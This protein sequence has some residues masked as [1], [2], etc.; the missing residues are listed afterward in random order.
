MKLVVLVFFICSSVI[1]ADP[2]Q[3]WYQ[4]QLNT[5]VLPPY[6]D[7]YQ[8]L[9][10]RVVNELLSVN[11]TAL[12]EVS[13]T[14]LANRLLCAARDVRASL[15]RSVAGSNELRNQ[16]DTK[17]TSSVNQIGAYEQ[18][19]VEK[20]VEIEQTNQ[21]LRG[22]EAALDSAKRAVLD[23]EA[24]VNA[25]DAAVRAAEDVVEKAKKCHGLL[26]R[27]KRSDRSVTN[28]GRSW[29]SSIT[30]PI[31]KPIENAIKDVIIKPVC[32]II[33]MGPLNDAKGR[34]DTARQE[35]QSARN[36]EAQYR[37][38]VANH[39]AH[40]NSLVDQLVQFQASLSMVQTALRVLQD[41]LA[42]T[43][44][45]N[46]QVIDLRKILLKL[47]LGNCRTYYVRKW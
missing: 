43:I 7:A 22:A 47:I 39:Q 35:L 10:T 42:I 17:V 46:D 16:I 23:K 45:I 19:I 9:Q 15:D 13:V 37:V 32:S 3:D 25:A 26:G 36:Q 20:E 31:V 21:H 30:R 34:L 44:T 28:M 27:R 29:F 8:I 24:S 2:Q 14:Q 11:I 41:E 33:N 18:N 12:D 40:K 4:A 6:R 1:N 5:N 38:T